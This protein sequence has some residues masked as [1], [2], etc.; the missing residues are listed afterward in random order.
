MKKGK[1][2]AEVGGEGGGEI[3]LELDRAEG[4]NF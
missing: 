2:K 3:L 1:I 4:R